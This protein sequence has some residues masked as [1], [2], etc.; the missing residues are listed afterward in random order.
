MQDNCYYG[1]ISLEEIQDHE[2]MLNEPLISEKLKKNGVLMSRTNNFMPYFIDN[3]LN[4][5]KFLPV[6]HSKNDLMIDLT[7]LRQLRYNNGSWF[8]L[9]N[10]IQKW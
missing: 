6:K 3:F 4:Y 2:Y 5:S 8:D 10:L 1:K 7:K 9:K